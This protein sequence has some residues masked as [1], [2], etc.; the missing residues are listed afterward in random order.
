LLEEQWQGDEVKIYES[1]KQQA[2]LLN[3]EISQLVKEIIERQFR[4]D[5]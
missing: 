4:E 5:N 3:K 1:L 2:N